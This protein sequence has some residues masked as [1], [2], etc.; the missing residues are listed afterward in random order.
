MST[1]EQ[2]YSLTGDS[3][4]QLRRD[5]EALR[6]IVVAESGKRFTD[7]RFLKAPKTPVLQAIQGTCNPVNALDGS[8]ASQYVTSIP[9]AK[10]TS[11]I[12][13]SVSRGT[14]INWLLRRVNSKLRIQ[15]LT[16]NTDPN[17]YPEFQ[18]Y[19][20]YQEVPFGSYMIAVRVIGSGYIPVWVDPC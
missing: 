5:H 18:N 19:S 1:E 3:I 14:M 6:A 20:L 8:S 15:N 7:Q 9:A 4:Q 11:M 17:T 16:V 13:G 12:R 2:G 10:L